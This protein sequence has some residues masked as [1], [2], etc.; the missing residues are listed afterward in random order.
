MKHI[1]NSP[2]SLRNRAL[3]CRRT[4]IVLSAAK[5]L[6]RYAA[7]EWPPRIERLKQRPAQT[8]R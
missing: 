7:F 2:K 8:A 6:R 1:G 4:R 5:A 3:Q